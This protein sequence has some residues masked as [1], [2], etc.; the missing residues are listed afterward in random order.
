LIVCFG[1]SLHIKKYLYTCIKILTYIE[2]YSLIGTTLLFYF[3]L[4]FALN[5]SDLHLEDRLH[6]YM[7]GGSNMSETGSSE[8]HWMRCDNRYSLDHNGI[9]AVGRERCRGGCRST[10]ALD[11]IFKMDMTNPI[12]GG[13]G[14]KFF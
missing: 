4:L 7:V 12:T 13:S 3:L 2:L 11:G 9:H 14:K 5:N 10:S 8:E 6:Q 1:C